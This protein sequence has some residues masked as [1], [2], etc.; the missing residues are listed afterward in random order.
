MQATSRQAVPVQAAAKNTVLIILAQPF[1]EEFVYI[2]P[3]QTQQQLGPHVI[4]IKT[5]RA[6]PGRNNDEVRE[7]LLRHYGGHG[8]TEKPQHRQ[9]AGL[10]RRLRDLCAARDVARDPLQVHVSVGKQHPKPDA[11]DHQGGQTQD[12]RCRPSSP[13]GRRVPHSRQVAEEAVGTD[14][15]VAVDVEPRR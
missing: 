2:D 12:G 15:A 13:A 6:D 7:H 5:D 9:A 4:K 14:G 1:R 3:V 11:R 10:G 8:D